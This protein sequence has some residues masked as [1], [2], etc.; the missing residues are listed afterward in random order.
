MTALRR[1]LVA[2]AG[3]AIAFMVISAVVAAGDLNATDLQ[4]AITF[5]GLWRPWL[6]TPAKVFSELG[7]VELTAL[8][9][10]GIA[11]YLYRLKFRSEAWVVV[12]Y[13]LVNA[14]EVLYKH[15]VNHPGPSPRFDHGDGPS[16]SELL[17]SAAGGSS[18][19]SGH[20]ARTV[21]VYGLLA[22]IAHRMAERR[23]VRM[24][25]V[26][27]AVVASLLIAVDR[28]YL[29]VHWESDVL[30][31]ALLGAVGLAA[32]VIWLDRPRG[33]PGE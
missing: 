9:S 31:G 4:V 27:L 28:L 32:A 12:T 23:W 26:P 25:A 7:G 24:V 5:S 10:A 18:Y 20:M 33:I 16:I 6:S 22:F 17:G 29:G 8:V 19:P 21:L 15:L 3:L 14:V 11:V 30:G 1:A 2:F 13:A